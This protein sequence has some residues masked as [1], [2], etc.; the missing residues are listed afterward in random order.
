MQDTQIFFIITMFL[1][2][3]KPIIGE[4]SSAVENTS[5]TQVEATKKPTG[6]MI[7]DILINGNRNTA[8]QI[9]MVTMNS[10]VGQPL[11]EQTLKNDMRA[12]YK[13]GYFQTPPQV[14]P[15]R[16]RG[17]LRLII[18]LEEN[19]LVESVTLEGNTLIPTEDLLKEMTTKPG[20]VLN[21]KQL[22]EDLS[23]ISALY[24]KKGYIYSGIYNPGR[25]VDIDGTKINI[26]LHES[27]ISKISIEGNKKTR[28]YVIMREL[29]MEEG[30]IMNRDGIADSLRNLRNLDFFELE[31][32]EINLDPETGDTDIKIRLKDM[33]TG[34]ASFGGG[35]SSVNGF[36]GFVD[37]TERNFR[38]KGQSLRVKTQFG[39]E[40]AYEL[41]FTEPYWKG[42]RQAI[43]ASIFRTI[44]DRDDIRNETLIS[45]FEEKREGFSVF[46][47]W[48][49][50]KDESTTL[51]F[52]DERIDTEVL[53]GQPSFLLD[54]HQQTIALT[55]VQDKRDN[56]QYP[57]SGY[58][59]SFS[60]STT[61]GI[62][63]GENNFNKYSHDFRKYWN[64][65]FIKKNTLAMRTKVGQ[66]GRAHV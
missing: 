10:K 7:T 20:S 23:L 58:R 38:G 55:W 29:L 6:P 35:Y 8:K 46:S 33:K 52:V 65:N 60:F 3:F 9:I 18:T 42:K 19:P 14:V 25:Q 12:I 37:A 34:T 41:A 39:G 31:Q 48:R 15:E 16:Y 40:Q 54:D 32:P 26:K 57:T 44:V 49:K 5:Q 21:I 2:L 43:G 64:N 45:R 63:A 50:K 66:I 53:A 56:F 47:S 1:L 13:L 28:D 4:E 36:V 22:Y 51:R 24:R 11:D 17:G 27:K 62:L 30:Q 59:H 61:G